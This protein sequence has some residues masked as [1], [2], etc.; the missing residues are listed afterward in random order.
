[1]EL[2][3]QLTGID[4]LDGTGR[5]GLDLTWNR[6]DWARRHCSFDSSRTTSR[7]GRHCRRACAGPEASLGGTVIAV[8]VDNLDVL[9]GEVEARS[10]ALKGWTG[11][12]D[13]G[14]VYGVAA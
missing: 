5:P 1:V 7:R 14:L 13:G 12:T 6:P 11:S 3:S 10:G 4:S 8:V 2:V 9:G